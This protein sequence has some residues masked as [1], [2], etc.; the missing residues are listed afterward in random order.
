MLLLTVHVYFCIL[1]F[2]LKDFWSLDAPEKVQQAE[3]FKEKGTKYFKEG[4]Y[5]LAIKIYQKMDDYI[6][7]DV[8]E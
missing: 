5:P 2:Q 3:F 7:N 1:L 6:G 4:K 8:G